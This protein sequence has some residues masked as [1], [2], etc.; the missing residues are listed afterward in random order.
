MAKQAGKYHPNQKRKFQNS[1]TQTNIKKSVENT[2][3]F[4]AFFSLSAN[5]PSN[6]HRTPTSYEFAK[7][8]SFFRTLSACLKVKHAEEDDD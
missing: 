4:N 3:F 2:K 5:S 8:P 7:S 6:V 1:T